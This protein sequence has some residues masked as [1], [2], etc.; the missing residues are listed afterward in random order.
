KYTG[1]TVLVTGDLKDIG[2]NLNKDICVRFDGFGPTAAQPTGLRVEAAVVPQDANKVWNTSVD[3]EIRVKG[4]CKGVDEILGHIN[5]MDC[6]VEGVG[7]DPSI[8]VTADDLL[9]EFAKNRKETDAKYRD[10]P[11]TLTDAV[12]DSILKDKLS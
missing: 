5:V 1:K 3:Q 4:M 10:K 6:T 9:A 12:I 7:P 8:V 11:V 2:F